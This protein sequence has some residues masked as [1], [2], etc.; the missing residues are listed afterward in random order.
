MWLIHILEETH[1]GVRKDGGY[2][3]QRRKDYIRMTR[4]NIKINIRGRLDVG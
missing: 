1:S 3:E 2:W 4:S